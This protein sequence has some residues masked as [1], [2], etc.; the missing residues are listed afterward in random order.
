MQWMGLSCKQFSMLVR[1]GLF[2]VLIKKVVCLFSTA[3]N[4]TK[5]FLAEVFSHMGDTGFEPVTPS[6]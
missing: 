3:K 4:D 2:P 5:Y 6:V 1:A